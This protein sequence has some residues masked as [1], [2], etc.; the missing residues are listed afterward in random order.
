MEADAE[1]AV[2]DGSMQFLPHSDQ[3]SKTLRPR[4]PALG[5]LFQ[6]ILRVSLR[7]RVPISALWISGI[8]SLCCVKAAL[9]LAGCL[10]PPLPRTPPGVRGTLPLCGNQTCILTLPTVPGLQN[11][12]QLRNTAIGGTCE[13][14]QFGVICE[15]RVRATLVIALGKLNRESV[16]LPS[17]KR[18]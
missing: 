13:D 2:P 11:H 6:D 15:R 1:V 16:T 12:S 4:E 7:H 14:I 17:M 3:E 8:Q 5:I 18:R 10:P 9:C